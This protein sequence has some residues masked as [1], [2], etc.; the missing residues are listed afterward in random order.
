MRLGTCDILQCHGVRQFVPPHTLLQ[1][2]SGQ[3]V[4]SRSSGH[5]L[6]FLCRKREEWH[7]RCHV[8]SRW[9]VGGDGK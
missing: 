7:G 9:M 6:W 3:A 2:L 1:Y 5:V 8:F 4:V